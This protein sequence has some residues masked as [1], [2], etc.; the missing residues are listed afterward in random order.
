MQ[1]VA[2]QGLGF[3]GCAMAVAT[4]NALDKKGRPL[5]NV[6]GVD[7]PTKAGRERVR[8]INA[9]RFPFETV[10]GKILDGAK[11][12]A[13]RGNLAA[14]TDSRVF[15]KADVILISINMDLVY[16]KDTPQADFASFKK[17]IVSIG[18]NVQEDALLIVET[19]VPPGTCEKIVRPVIAEQ[20]KK[21]G[22]NPDTIHIAHSYE[23]VMP[24]AD[25]LDSIVNFWRVYAGTTAQ[26][27]D[28]CEAFLSRIINCRQYPLTRLPST[29]ASETAKVLEN[30]Y[31]AMNIAF[32]EEWGR[33]AEA[34]GIDL[35]AV[36]DAIRRRP[37]HSNIR[38]PG[39]GVGGY[40]L[41]KDPLFARIAAREIFGLS[42]HTFPFSSQAVAVN[43]AMP[44]VSLGKIREYFRG[45][46]EGKR[47]LLMGISY[48]QDVGDTRYSPAE[49]FY[50]QAVQE[51]ALVTPHDPLVK[52]WDE[53]R[54]PVR[55]RLPRPAGFD[56]VVF[57]VPHAAYRKI[58]FGRWLKTGG[59][60]LVFDA[61]NVLTVQQRRDITRRGNPLLSIGR[62]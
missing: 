30:S 33:F 61:N 62:G 45:S 39:F 21:R 49:T 13:A 29:T 2:I 9:G 27:A 26:A 41:T 56:A 59:K 19:T 42:G 23:R 57:A 55:R 20:V 43:Q 54:I 22:L 37:T 46:V 60:P 24:G 44:L 1:T 15:G 10:D 36:I 17:A 28:R 4:A 34:V 25:Y 35:Y 6:M 12:A 18:E 51:G 16:V 31:R 5:F 58:D 40:C 8:L 14:T 3:V 7:L 50:R 53:L 38:Q 32:I 11:R 47:I 52:Y 48:R